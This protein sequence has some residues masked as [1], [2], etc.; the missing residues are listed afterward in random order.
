MKDNSSRLPVLLTILGLLLLAQFLWIPWYNTIRAGL[1]DIQ[2]LS[3]TVETRS[4]ALQ[5]AASN[6]DETLYAL[7]QQKEQFAQQSYSGVSQ[8]MAEA[9][10]LVNITQLA[11]GSNV[12]LRSQTLIPAYE[13][14]DF[15]ILGVEITGTGPAGDVVSFLTQLANQVPNHIVRRVRLEANQGGGVFLEAHVETALLA[16]GEKKSNQAITRESWTVVPSGTLFGSS[17][18]IEN[19]QPTPVPQAE[20]SDLWSLVGVVAGSE[21]ATAVLKRNTTGETRVVQAGDVLEEATVAFIGADHV[22][23]STSQGPRY[24]TVSQ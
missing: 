15:L 8:A 23:L 7:H 24:L 18:S 14:G 5:N 13:Q 10:M 4:A 17:H 19:V 3:F 22:I 21:R 6:Y 9:Q 12:N 20:A 11:K 16:D 2:Q 1:E